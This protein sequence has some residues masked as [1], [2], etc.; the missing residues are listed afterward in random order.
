PPFLGDGPLSETNGVKVAFH[1]CLASATI[2]EVV[3]YAIALVLDKIAL[4]GFACHLMALWLNLVA[5]SLVIVLWSNTLN[6]TRRITTIG[7]SGFDEEEGRSKT[8]CGDRKRISRTAVFVGIVDVIVL[9]STVAVLAT[10]SVPSAYS[11]PYLLLV[12][13]YSVTLFLLAYWLVLYGVRLQR[14]VMSHPRWEPLGRRQQVKIL[15]RINGVVVVCA[16]CFLLRIVVLSSA[17]FVRSRERVEE[18][19]HL[20]FEILARW[21][22]GLVPGGALLYIMRKTGREGAERSPQTIRC[23]RRNH[24]NHHTGSHVPCTSTSTSTTKCFKPVLL[25]PFHYCIR[26]TPRNETLSEPLIRHHWGD[27][28]QAAE[29]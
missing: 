21:I 26:H 1:F 9:V 18:M 15:C 23:T 13:T 4:V 3:N 12:V 8:I 6:P 28:G 20:L 2:L 25:P 29:T 5:F 11:Q 16:I 27:S 7:R 17:L 10:S 24:R 22:P 19:N 14:R